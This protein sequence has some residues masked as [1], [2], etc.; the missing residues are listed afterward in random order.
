[1]L[2]LFSQEAMN[3]ESIPTRSQAC[4]S[5][6][7]TLSSMVTEPFP[8]PVSRCLLI[9]LD[10]FRTCEDDY[11]K[12]KNSSYLD[13]SPLYGSNQQD[14]NSIRLHVDGLLK[15]DAFAE[16]RVLGFPPGVAALLVCFN[17]YHN[18]V[19]MQLKDINEGGRFD[20]PRGDDGRRL[21]KLDNDL[22]QTAR[23]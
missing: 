22:F 4:S 21:A 1:M 6:W 18:F 12:L 20:T 16:T 8:T 15:P 3:Q 13:L 19:A 17:R 5:T 23:L 11:S 14:Q 7:P 9:H 2:K 10:L